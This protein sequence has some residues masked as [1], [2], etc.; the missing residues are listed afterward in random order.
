MPTV[1]RQSNGKETPKKIAA[2]YDSIAPMPV[3]ARA[4]VSERNKDAPVSVAACPDPVTH[5]ALVVTETLP[6]DTPEDTR[7]LA[8]SARAS[9]PNTTSVDNPTPIVPATVNITSENS[10]D[11]TLSQ[12]MSNSIESFS[13]KFNASDEDAILQE[14]CFDSLTGRDYLRTIRYTD[15]KHSLLGQQVSVK[16][17]RGR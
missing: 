13:D 15:E 10:A 6:E 9:S 1:I 14:L 7:A 16:G 2:L 17:S 11:L 8:V 4:T 3:A 5:R 12:G